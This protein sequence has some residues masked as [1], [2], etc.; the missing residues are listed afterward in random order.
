MKFVLV[1]YSTVGTFASAK[2]IEVQEAGIWEE[3][4]SKSITDIGQR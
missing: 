4:D 1:N 3:S 2:L